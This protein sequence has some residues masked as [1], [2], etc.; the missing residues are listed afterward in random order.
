[1]DTKTCHW[2]CP[3]H[4]RLSLGLKASPYWCRCDSVRKDR[5]GGTACA[6][7]IRP[8]EP[9]TVMTTKDY[10]Y[11]G[12]ILLAALAF[13]C[14]GFHAGIY[15]CKRMYDTLLDNAQASLDNAQAG[16]SGG[17]TGGKLLSEQEKLVAYDHEPREPKILITDRELR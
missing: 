6:V 10:V 7:F 14:N 13:Y 8:V 17:S 1:M 5:P 2:S 3:G 4:I 15:R 9:G 12:L 11:L 16:S